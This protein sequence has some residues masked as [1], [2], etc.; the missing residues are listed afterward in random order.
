MLFALGS[1]LNYCQ[2]NEDQCCTVAYFDEQEREILNDLRSGIQKEL[3]GSNYRILDSTN[4]NIRNCKFS[5][6]Y[7]YYASI[8]N[9]HN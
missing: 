3:L 7:N 1:M 6:Y 4:D 5:V 2:T 8:Y 9:G